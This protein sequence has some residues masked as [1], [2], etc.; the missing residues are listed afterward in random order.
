MKFR[1]LTC[2]AL[3]AAPVFAS[4]SPDVNVPVVPPIAAPDLR[5]QTKPGWSLTL[6]PSAAATTP[7]AWP[8]AQASDA[9]SAA[10]TPPLTSRL[11]MTAG[12]PVDLNMPMLEP[13][14]GIDFKLRYAPVAVVPAETNAS[15]EP[16]GKM[17][18]IRLP[19]R[20]R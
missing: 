19:T 16:A 2:A 17:P 11:P 9:A 4:F 7:P 20:G 5:L 13:P 1:L 12:Q 3:G 18:A 10:T 6:E 15:A 14:A 8:R